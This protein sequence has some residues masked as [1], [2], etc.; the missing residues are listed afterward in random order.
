MPILALHNDIFDEYF[1]KYGPFGILFDNLDEMAACI[2]KI[3]CLDIKKDFYIKNIKIAKN[4]MSETAF[5][6][7]LS[8]FIQM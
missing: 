8:E 5:R 2:N 1:K 4:A 7:K 3:N 6:E